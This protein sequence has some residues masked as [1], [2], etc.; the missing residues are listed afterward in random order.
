MCGVV[1]LLH[2][3]CD[4]VEY[5]AAHR[6]ILLGTFGHHTRVSVFN[7]GMLVI[8]ISLLFVGKMRLEVAE[9]RFVVMVISEKVLRAKAECQ[10][11]AFSTHRQSAPSFASDMLDTAQLTAQI[12]MI[13]AIGQREQWL[14]EEEVSLQRSR[15]RVGLEWCSVET[16]MGRQ[17]QSR[18]R[19]CT[20]K[21]AW[22]LQ[23]RSL[24]NHRRLRHPNTVLFHQAC[25]DEV[26]RSGV[27]RRPVQGALR[28][29]PD[30]L[31]V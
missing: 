26:T 6:N 1:V 30:A 25:V 9:R 19:R 31:R 12:D 10:L 8:L 4:Q 23:G 28:G 18:Y 22:R 21:E 7:S 5:L 24:R 17:W 11:A 16:S 2:G 3:S 15:A 27:L 20:G 29:L 13:Q 14:L